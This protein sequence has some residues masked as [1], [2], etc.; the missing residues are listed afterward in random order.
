[1]LCLFPLLFQLINPKW[2]V[3][4]LTPHHQHYCLIER[5]NKPVAVGIANVGRYLFCRFKDKTKW[6]MKKEKEQDLDTLGG[7]WRLGRGRNIEL[8]TEQFGSL[9]LPNWNFVTM[10]SQVFLLLKGKAPPS[11][12]P[13]MNGL[14]RF[15]L[16][17]T[18]PPGLKGG[19]M[20]W[21]AP[22][23]RGTKL[24]RLRFRSKHNVGIPAK[25]GSQNQGGL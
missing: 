6:A 4:T 7:G 15:L 5:V 2:A 24:L 17:E 12:F 8:V 3:F 13:W 10:K 1:M 18:F 9:G 19:W 11:S 16:I 21:G 22:T 14:P 23:R 25:S 20:E